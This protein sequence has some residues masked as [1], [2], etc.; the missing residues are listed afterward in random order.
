MLAEPFHLSY[1]YVFEW[2]GELFMIPETY[3]A[4]S[5]R[6]YKADPFPSRWSFVTTLVTGKEYVDASLAR[7]HDKW[8]LFAVTGSDPARTEDLHL[9][10]ADHLLGLWQ[11][12]PRSPVIEKNS[13]IARPGGRVLCVE[14]RLF[15]YTQD[16]AQTYGR[17][18]RAFEVTELT[19]EHY[20]EKSVSD[21]PILK[22]A[23]WMESDGD[24][25]C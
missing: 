9:F 7:F 3:Q 23:D 5:I 16:C 19:T 17:Q 15:R 8:W 24:A 4:N 13:M 10:F 12:H 2:Q 1:P 11:E 21:E 22:P 18:V 6:L 25:S 20:A 14:N